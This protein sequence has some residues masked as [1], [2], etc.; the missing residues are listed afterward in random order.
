MQIGYGMAPRGQMTQ[1]P[2]DQG[3][4]QFLHQMDD[5][6][7]IPWC[8]LHI[9]HSVIT[10]KLIIHW[11]D[12]PLPCLW[13]LMDCSELSDDAIVQE[14]SIWIMSSRLM[15]CGIFHQEVRGDT[16]HLL[17]FQ[18]KLLSSG[19]PLATWNLLVSPWCTWTQFQ[20]TTQEQKN[21]SWNLLVSSIYSCSRLELNLNPT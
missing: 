20:V 15:V 4:S 13:S 1:V 6:S 17:L 21:C 10:Q 7:V 11:L 18:I 12:Y 5:E 9:S 16:T 2:E 3:F 14:R 8:S 19:K